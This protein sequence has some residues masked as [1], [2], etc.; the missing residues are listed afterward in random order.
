MG[1]GKESE[2]G[3]QKSDV[4][5]APIDSHF[6]FLIYESPNL[7]PRFDTASFFVMALASF[8]KDP[9]VVCHYKKDIVESGIKLLKKLL[10]DEF[11][12]F[13][14]FLCLDH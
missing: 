10:F 1:N 4:F 7:V 11:E 5:V 14:A 8:G 13:I 12:V 6:I 9:Q 2:A 3:S